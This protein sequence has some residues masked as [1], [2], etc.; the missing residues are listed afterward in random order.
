MIW[1]RLTTYEI[2]SSKMLNCRWRSLLSCCL[3]LV[4]RFCLPYSI[5]S[6]EK[7]YSFALLGS[8]ENYC[9]CSP[10]SDPAQLSFWLS[11]TFL[12]NKRFVC[13]LRLVLLLLPCTIIIVMPVSR[14]AVDRRMDYINSLF[15]GIFPDNVIIA[16][17]CLC[18]AYFK[19]F[20]RKIEHVPFLISWNF[21]K[22][23]T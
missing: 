11:W 4:V 14:H 3:A 17:T 7:Y 22:F 16:F 18:S 23:Q 21:W 2:F 10:D 13:Q 1:F 5:I 19:L 15:F 20:F 8:L 12:T 9:R 6:I